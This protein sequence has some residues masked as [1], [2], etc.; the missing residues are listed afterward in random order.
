MGMTFRSLACCERSQKLANPGSGTAKTE[1]HLTQQGNGD[2]A[3]EMKLRCDK[4]TSSVRQAGRCRT[5]ILVCL[6]LL[7]VLLSSA[8]CTSSGADRPYEGRD[9]WDRRSTTDWQ[10]Y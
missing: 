3:A 10:D 7:T 1:C 5:S 4:H 6:L 2:G 8:G 9:R